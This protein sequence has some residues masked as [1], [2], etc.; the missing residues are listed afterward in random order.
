MFTATQKRARALLQQDCVGSIGGRRS[1]QHAKLLRCAIK[2]HY[3]YAEET[4]AYQATHRTAACA[5]Q[6]AKL[7]C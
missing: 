4:C 2:L 1:G 6:F 7:E 3:A 5:R